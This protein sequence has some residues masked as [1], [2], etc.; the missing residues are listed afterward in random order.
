M[1]IVEE[2][3]REHGLNRLLAAVHLSKGTWYYERRRQP[4]EVRHADLRRPLLRAVEDHS[5][6]GYRKLR[7]ELV[8]RGIP[9]SKDVV[10]EAAKRWNLATKRRIHT[11]L[12]GKVRRYL[13][14]HAGA[15]DL[16]A[17]LTSIDPFQVFF[18]DFTQ[19]VFANGADR[20]WLMVLLEAVSRLVVGW[21]LSETCT[22]AAALEAW[23]MAKRSLFRFGRTPKGVIVH[24]DQ[25]GPY[26]SDTWVRTLVVEDGARVSYSESG[27]KGNTTQESFNGHFKG[28]NLSLFLNSPDRPE[29]EAMVRA[30][31]VYYNVERRHSSLG[32]V[33]PIE[34]LRLL[35][36]KPVGGCSLIKP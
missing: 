8:G 3:L 6:Y 18:T 2:N 29:L 25:G 33:S 26:I 19:I 14:E 21:S 23:K 24:H 36:I 27:A 9:V 35:G 12:P 11:P 13:N 7:D 4:F 34:F 32:N 10:R 5:E 16:V 30:R 31:L 22:A 28:E 15:C 17:R 1:Q 20:L